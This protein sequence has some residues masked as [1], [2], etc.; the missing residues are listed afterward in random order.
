M[1]LKGVKLEHLDQ[2][3][4]AIVDSL[5]ETK[6]SKIIHLVGDLGAGKTTLVKSIAKVLGI[7]ASVQSP[8]FVFMREYETK[9]KTIKKLYHIDAYRFENK[10]EG[11][12]L[13]LDKIQNKNT[14]TIIEWPEKMHAGDPD[15]ILT[16][17]HK[18][19]NERDIDVKH[20]VKKPDV[21]QK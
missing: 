13:E 6:T 8:T 2:V 21:K 18:N 17:K 15:I 12:V 3:A 10:D 1:K 7:T 14:L 9:H 20:I 11:K 16:L 19:E 5:N 4:T